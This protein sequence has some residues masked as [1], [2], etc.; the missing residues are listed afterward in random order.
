ML[1]KRYH[2]RGIHEHHKELETQQKGFS[3]SQG[4]GG[5]IAR[6]QFRVGCLVGIV[7]F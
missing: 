6:A 7:Y 3:I 1:F 4:G 2:R 5:A